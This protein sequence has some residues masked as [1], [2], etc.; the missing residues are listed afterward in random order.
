VNLFIPSTL[1]WA[2]RKITVQQATD[3]PYADTTRLII[4]G[5]GRFDLKVRI[6]GWAARGVVVKIN[7]RDQAVKATPGAYLTLSRTW[8]DKDTIE[9]KMPF[10]FRLDHLVDQPNVASLFYGPVL[11]AA[12]EPAPRTDWRLVSLDRNDISRSI[13]GDPATLRFSIAGVPFKPFYETYGRHSVYLHVS[14]K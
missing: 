5:S 14:F 13:Q 3:F 7:G 6:P 2:E 4:K 10:T 11:L 1:T 12:E 9:L 8:R